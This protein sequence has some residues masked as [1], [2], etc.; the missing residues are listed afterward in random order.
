MTRIT[1]LALLAAALLAGCD[2]TDTPP[3]PDAAT[4]ARVADGD[5]LV[6]DGGERVRLL[7]IDAPELGGGDCHGR[8]AMRELERLLE[9]GDRVR[10]E[11]DPEL[12]S[13][14]RFGRLLRYVHVED[15]NVNVE[16]VRLGAAA[17][18]FFRGERGRYADDLLS[19]VEEARTEGAGMWHACDVRWRP[20][21][22]VE[23]GAR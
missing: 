1:L 17:P 16:L 22:Q 9:P 10:L 6:L 2:A 5:T 19:A 15:D 23:T 18:F 4:I 3:P 20:D 14:D 8:E 13:R 7:Q 11:L 12:D 21:R